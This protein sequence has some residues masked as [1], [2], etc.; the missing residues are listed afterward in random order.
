MTPDT[1][2][3]FDRGARVL[4]TG[5]L[6]FIGS[7]LARRLVELGSEVTVVDSML[8]NTGAN[9]ANLRDIEGRLQIRVVDLR[10][11]AEIAALLPGHDVVFN[12]AGKSSHSDSMSDPLADLEANVNAHVVLLDGCRKHIPNAKIV[13]SSTRQIYGRPSYCPV[14]E[15]HP[16]RPLDVNGINKSAGET[17]HTLY[18]N[19]YGLDTICLRLTNTFGP[20]MRIKDARQ[21]FLGIWVRRVV[22]GDVFEVWGGQQKRDLTFIDDAVEAFLLAAS[23]SPIENGVFNIGGNPPI[24]LAEL[25]EVLITIAGKGRYEFKQFPPDRLRIDLGDYFADDSLFRKATGWAPKFSL[26]QA[27]AR[28]VEFYMDRLSDYV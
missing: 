27:L 8:P 1:N 7:N 18:R 24:S 10:N 17:Y 16:V 3:S 5:G 25:G 4:V 14:D 21:N 26:S 19:I 2:H 22:E 6:G 9:W 28:T 20:R 15:I 12:L 11:A 13:Y 23:T